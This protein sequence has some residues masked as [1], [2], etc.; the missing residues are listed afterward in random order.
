M[1]VITVILT[2]TNVISL[3]VALLYATEGGINA[4]IVQGKM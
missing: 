3:E 1:T 2:S 4:C